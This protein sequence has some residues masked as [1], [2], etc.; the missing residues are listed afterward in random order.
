MDKN[1]DEIEI[2]IIEDFDI[3]DYIRSIPESQEKSREVLR[4]AG[5]GEE[6][7]E[8]MLRLQF[9]GLFLEA[10]EEVLR[11]KGYSEDKIEGILKFRRQ[12]E[13]LFGARDASSYS[14]PT[15]QE[16]KDSGLFAKNSEIKPIFEGQP[17]SETKPL[18]KAQLHPLVK[19]K[20]RVKS[21]NI[22]YRRSTRG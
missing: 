13:E 12:H 21:Q 10:S 22:K 7:I 16:V 20:K 5:Y 18:P 9:G 14:N 8:E 19:L 17:Y 6:K 2:E 3:N 1:K 15:H 11:E 4:E